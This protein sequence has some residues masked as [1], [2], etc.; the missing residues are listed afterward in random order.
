MNTDERIRE[1]AEWANSVLRGLWPVM[2]PDLFSSLVD[3]LE[4]I[5]QGSVPSFIVRRSFITNTHSC[6]GF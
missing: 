4:D 3:M 6:A 2:N 1:S 5:M